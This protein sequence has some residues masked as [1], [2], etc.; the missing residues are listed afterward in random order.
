MRLRPGGNPRL[1]LL[2]RRGSE[3]LHTVAGQA[4]GDHRHVG[5]VEPRK[6]GR[7]PGIDD[8]C[9]RPAVTQDLALA[10]DFEDLVAA[11]RDRVGDRAEVVGGVDA[12]VVD[13]EIDGATV[14]S[15]LG[16]DDQAGDER[17][18]DD[19]DDEVRGKTRGHGGSADSI[20]R[21][22]FAIK[23]RSLVPD[24]ASGTA[25]RL[26]RLARTSRLVLVSQESA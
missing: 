11:Y 3:Q 6:D 7:S 21:P 26:P 4:G 19:D 17:A 18:G 15:A 5:I 14:V 16:S 12:R 2:D 20:T 23:S 8:R 10:A 24:A 22:A 25:A 9:L 13:D 1:H